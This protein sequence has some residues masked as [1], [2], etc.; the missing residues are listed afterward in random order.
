[1][2]SWR[3]PNKSIKLVH[4]ASGREVWLDKPTEAFDAGHISNET[5]EA[6]RMF[7]VYPNGFETEFK[8]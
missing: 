8:L 2:N 7:N 1:M 3:S 4:I 5:K 6:W